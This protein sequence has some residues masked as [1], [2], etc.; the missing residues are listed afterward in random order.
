MTCRG[1]PLMMTVS[2]WPP[3]SGSAAHLAGIRSKLTGQEVEQRRLARAVRPDDADAVAAQDLGREVAHHD[4]LAEA[5][6][7]R[8]GDDD[9][10]AGQLC[11]GS[12]E[13]DAA[14][15]T[16]QRAVPLAQRV[17]IAQ[18]LDVA[19]ASRG[20]AV[21]QPVL[22]HHELA[23]QLV[24]I[25][26]F[27]FQHL[28]APRLELG[29]IAVEA[30][31]GATIDPGDRA[32]QALEQAPVVADDDECRPQRGEFALQPGDRRQIEVVGRLVEQQDVWRRS[33]RAREC[34]TTR[35]AAGETGGL[36]VAGQAEFV[37]QVAG[38]VWV[39]ARTE[40]CL[41]VGERARVAGEIRLLGKIADR[42]TRLQEA[43]ARILR[44]QARRDL[45][46]R[47]FA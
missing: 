25:A 10:P 36:L 20:H 40:A 37:E 22:L 31:G 34:G 45:E 18:S 8:L 21:A 17:Q 39:I 13:L 27:L 16:A 41:G 35:L 33:Q 2:P 23:A 7:D 42:G 9:L 46:Q 11:L 44:Q 28:V 14:G 24:L 32:R 26:R 38:A 5:L 30:A 6:F 15:G 4:T 29:E 1:L 47:G 19:L 43:G 12:R 3:V